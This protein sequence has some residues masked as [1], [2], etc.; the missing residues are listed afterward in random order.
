LSAVEA[1]VDAVK[2]HKFFVTAAFSDYASIYYDNLAEGL[3]EH[4][5]EDDDQG[6]PIGADEAA[7]EVQYKLGV[8]R[9]GVSPMVADEGL[10][11]KVGDERA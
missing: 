6:F 4:G 2:G 1:G 7:D 10:D 11:E 5:E 3:D 9:R 8:L